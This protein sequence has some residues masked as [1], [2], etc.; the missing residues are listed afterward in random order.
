MAGHS[1]WNNIRIKKGRMDA[2]RGKLFT[3][4]SKEI[5]VAGKDGAD[6]ESNFRLKVAIQRAKKENL[7]AANI[8]RLLKKL[9]GGGGADDL[10]EVS[11]EG[12]G[13][14]GV[15]ILVEATTDNRN[16]TAAE[17]RLVF[18]KNNGSVGEAGCV[19]W[20][21]DRRGQLMISRSVCGEEELLLAGMEA[22]ALDLSTDEGDEHYALF[23]EQTDLHQVRMALEAEGISVED[24]HF[25]MIPKNRVAVSAEDAVSCL[26][27]AEALEDQ[28]DVQNVFTN[29]EL[30]DELMAEIEDQL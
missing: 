18:N 15:A 27:L 24:A 23:T 3:K 6:P 17:V 14:G 16:R 30:T 12:Y 10:E 11:Y 4:L 25:T 28:D 29:I 5:L 22:G 20:L 21:F 9:G 19:G 13:S 7:P 8:E 26:R 2:K 1:K